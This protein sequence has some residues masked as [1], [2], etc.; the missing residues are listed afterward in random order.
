MTGGT[1]SHRSVTIMAQ[2]VRRLGWLLVWGLAVLRPVALAQPL[3]ITVTHPRNLTQMQVARQVLLAVPTGN[4]SDPFDY[5]YTPAGRVKL[6]TGPNT[7]AGRGG[8]PTYQGDEDLIIASK[9]GPTGTDP[10]DPAYYGDWTS[11]FLVA[12]DPDS[13]NPLFV[14]PFQ[15]ALDQDQ[16]DT[17]ADLTRYW[18]QDFSAGARDAVGVARVPIEFDNNKNPTGWLRIRVEYKLIG[19]TLQ[20]SIEV[21]NEGQ[22]EHAIGLRICFDAGFDRP[23]GPDDGQPVFLA[24]GQAIVAETVINGPF[25]QDNYTWTSYDPNNPLIA[26]RGLVG[27]SETAELYNPGTATEAAGMPDRMEFGQLR[28]MGV[29]V[30]DFVPN[31]GA[32]LLG[33]DWAYAVRWDAKP[34]A[35]GRSRR[36]VTWYGVGSSTPSYDFPFA[37]MAYVPPGLKVVQDPLTAEYKIVDSFNQSPFPVAVYVDNYG[38]SPLLNASARLRLPSGF[39]L[40][41]GQPTGNLGIIPHDELKWAVWQVKAIATRPG[42]APFRFTGPDGR[43]VTATL[44]VPVIPILYPLPSTYPAFEMVSFPFLFAN[45]S[46]ASVLA[47]L[48]DLSPGGPQTIVRYDPTEANPDLRYK[49]FPDAFAATIEPGKG[50]WL[51]NLN[52]LPV[53]MPADR[54]PV[55]TDLAFSLVVYKGWNQIGNPFQ[56]TVN[57]MDLQVTDAANRRWTMQEAIDRQLLLPT[58]FWW[59]PLE[60]KYKWETDPT[61][62]T[63]DPYMGYWLLAR[64]DLGLLVPP[65]TYAWTAQARAARSAG[66]RLQP[67]GWR[68]T[69]V[70]STQA[71]SSEPLQLGVAADGRQGWDLWDLPAPP[72]PAALREARVQAFIVGPEQTP[73]LADIRPQAQSALEWVVEVRTNQPGAAVKLTWP[74]LS[75]VPRDR[76]PT[77]V[78]LETGNCCYMRTATQYVYTSSAS[79]APRRFKILVSPQGP[80]VPMI[81]AAQVEAGRGRAVVVYTLS[82]AAEVKL[83]VRN[84]SGRP[85]RELL[86]GRLQPAGLNQVVWNG[87]NDAGS[88]VPAGPYLVQ[89]T[90]RSPATGQ[91]YQVVRRLNLLR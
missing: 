76:L 39:E 20:T 71:A 35:P 57:L 31:P 40:D 77:L 72:E 74:D 14:D 16:G 87:T 4:T 13:D 78:D 41:S 24:S 50:Y 1:T 51:L 88:P 66:R 8:N 84:L 3:A 52:Q 67:S 61:R 62:V 6:F 27:T 32:P 44:P 7:P 53:V 63:M 12:V 36:F 48:G 5:W 34:L 18:I 73:C 58:L 90:A 45:S 65:P 15:L 42:R 19:D 55:P 28:N 56:Y 37:M 91:L 80:G 11:G 75:S 9:R 54:S 38:P 68:L 47:S 46:A 49:F 26:V 89:I 79:G 21:T 22:Q 83:V 70:A 59:D 60:H 10:A 29:G 2:G 33:N 25:T 85:V 17:A 81:T 23:G 86:S 82:A 43:T 30:W 69:L 64:E